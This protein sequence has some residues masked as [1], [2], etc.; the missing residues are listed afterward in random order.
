[1]LEDKDF[2]TMDY[3]ILQYG[4]AIRN[5]YNSIIKNLH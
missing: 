4:E 5:Y 2:L 3:N 1:M